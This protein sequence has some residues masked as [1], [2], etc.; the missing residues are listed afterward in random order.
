MTRPASIIGVAGL[1]MLAAVAAAP[2][3]AATSPTVEQQI[4]ALR[5]IVERQ[6]A[7]LDSQRQ[8][9]DIQRTEI[10]ALRT[11][12][13][14]PVAQG[15]VPAVAATPSAMQGSMPAV[16]AGTDA[17]RDIANAASKPAVD[18][19][20][21]AGLKANRPSITSADGRSS[22]AVRA[23]VQMDY[24]HYAQDPAG[25]LA[26]D[27]RRGSVGATGRETEAARD[28]SDGTYFRRARLGIEGIFSQDFSYRLLLEFGGSGTEAQGRIND[29]YVMYTGLAPFAF[30]LGA[31]SPPANLADGTATEDLLFIERSTPAELSRALGGA[32]GRFGLGVRVNGARGLAALTLTGRTATDPEVFDSQQAVV[33]R[34]GGLALTAPDYNVHLGAN[35]TYVLQP[36]DLS[37]AAS[38]RYGIRFR[39]RP[40]IRVDSTRLIDTGAIDAEHAYSAGLEFAANWK[41]VMLQAE[42]FWYG[43]ERR[44]STLAEPRFGGYYV[45]ASWFP[46]G[47][48]RRYAA[49]NAAFQAPKPLLPFDGRGGW[50][51]W[52]LALRY[53]HTDLNELAGVPGTAAAADSVR[54]GEQS[55]F[56][57]GVNWYLT[58]NVKLMFN[59]LR[60][61]VDRLNPA[62]PD[63]PTP[64]GPSP[65]T[66][67]LGVNVGQELDVYA[68][69]SQFN[70]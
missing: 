28:L 4:E 21:T 15:T 9:L 70:F 6:Q 14:V 66:P 2:T 59:Y 5:E 32:D 67:P 3:L 27:Y 36:P 53:S 17:S 19:P 45:E 12:Q 33:G 25:P 52:E 30:Q 34:L 69:R 56:G 10:E 58:P 20:A 60:V 63:N 46:T 23:N 65:A 18:A 13:G 42:N 37:S 62:G 57:A 51:A 38:P 64:F 61:D 41:N 26:T 55:I 29:A 22:V 7:Q 39:D 44:D 11:G 48:R 31:Y 47:E 1:A 16:A 43:I 40:E 50:G 35:G 54:G 8:Q 24:A 68:V 49:T